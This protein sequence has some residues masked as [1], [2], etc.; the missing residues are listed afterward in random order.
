M[1][2][3]SESMGVL[4][5]TAHEKAQQGTPMSAAEQRNLADRITAFITAKNGIPPPDDVDSLGKL[6][7]WLAE[8]GLPQRDAKFAAQGGTDIPQGPNGTTILNP[9]LLFR[10]GGGNETWRTLFRA[11]ASVLYGHVVGAA[12]DGKRLVWRIRPEVDEQRV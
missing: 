10:E 5:K 6:N 9:G 2:R 11:V 1:S 7:E 3:I 4:S 12:E 8:C